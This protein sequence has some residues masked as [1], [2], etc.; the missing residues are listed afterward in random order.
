MQN[1]PIYQT[2]VILHD[3]QRRTWKAAIV[4]SD[5]HNWKKNPIY[6]EINLAFMPHKPMKGTNVFFYA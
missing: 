5:L 3:S 6:M 4:K 2:N 1:K